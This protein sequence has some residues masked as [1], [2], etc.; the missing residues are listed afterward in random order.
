MHTSLHGSEGA[1]TALNGDSRGRMLSLN[2]FLL[3]SGSTPANAWTD[4]AFENVE[5]FSWEKGQLEPLSPDDAEILDAVAEGDI[6]VALIRRFTTQP[7]WQAFIKDAFNLTEFGAARESLGAAVFC[8]ASAAVDDGAVRWG[9]LDLRDCRTRAQ[10]LCSRSKVWITC[11]SEPA[12]CAASEFR[13]CCC[14]GSG[15]ASPWSSATGDEVPDDLAVR[16]ANR[17]P[18]RAGHT[19]RR[20]PGRPD[21]RPHR[22]SRRHRGRSSPDH[23]YAAGRTVTPVQGMD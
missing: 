4:S 1:K 13:G 20:L 5:I 22:G 19:Y 21:Q 14:P 15:S 6:I 10:A 9:C 3:R 8:A 7:P 2:G 23:V 16:S 11:R 12:G 18:G 17:S